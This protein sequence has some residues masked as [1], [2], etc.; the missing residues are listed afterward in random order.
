MKWYGEWWGIVFEP[1]CEDDRILLDKLKEV[2]GKSATGGRFYDYGEMGW[3]EETGN[4]E[5][6]R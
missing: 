5:I 3:N 6:A 4:F 1:E 2:S